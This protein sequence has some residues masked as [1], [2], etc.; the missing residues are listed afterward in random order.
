M[1]K[2][3]IL[4]LSVVSAVSVDC[5]FDEGFCSWKQA[6]NNVFNWTWGQRWNISIQNT[7]TDS[8]QSSGG[9]KTSL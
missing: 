1:L 5:T 9:N 3:N 2:Y 6:V 7:D 4:F 8:D